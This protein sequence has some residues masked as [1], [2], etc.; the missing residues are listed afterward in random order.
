MKGKRI[1]IA[2]TATDKTED[3]SSTVEDVE[4]THTFTQKLIHLFFTFKKA[5]KN[6]SR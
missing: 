6:I 1:H 2:Q 5:P 3:T 4:N